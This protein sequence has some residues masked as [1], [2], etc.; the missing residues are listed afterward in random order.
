M[1]AS[2]LVLVLA[3]GC[4]AELAPRSTS[5]LSDPSCSDPVLDACADGCTELKAVPLDATGACVGPA[6]VRGC[7]RSTY[8]PLAVDR[9]GCAVLRAEGRVYYLS[10]AEG[11]RN[12]AWRSCTEAESA[13][14]ARA[15]L[16][17]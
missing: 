14:F 12:A 13:I 9:G 3:L 17:Y 7:I 1:R 10:E 4:G 11:V 6:R 5:G 8:N 15:G 16:C 2:P